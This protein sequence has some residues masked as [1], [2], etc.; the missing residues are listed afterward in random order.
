ME[1]VS[2]QFFFIRVL[3]F[4]SLISLAGFGADYLI[5]VKTNTDGFVFNVL[6]YSVVGLTAYSLVLFLASFVATA[7]TSKNSF[8]L[9]FHTVFLADTIF[10]YA[11][12]LSFAWFF[13]RE[14]GSSVSVSGS[15]GELVVN[16]LYTILG[17]KNA[18]YNARGAVSFAIVLHF[19]FIVHN[20][21]ATRNQLMAERSL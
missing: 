16:G 3:I 11:L 9:T 5:G 6:F 17:W 18:A 8:S 14:S 10:S 20:Y 7:I 13:L 12:V 19:L 1:T 2:M 4:A 21:V 15:Q